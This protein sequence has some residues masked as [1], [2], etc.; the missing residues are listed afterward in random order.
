MMTVQNRFAE[1]QQN[2]NIENFKDPVLTA[3]SK[4]KSHPSITPIKE[5]SKN[6]K[7]SFHEVNNEKLRK[8]SGD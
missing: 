2:N 4:Y 1:Q 5:K 3:I 8:K 7:L 6:A